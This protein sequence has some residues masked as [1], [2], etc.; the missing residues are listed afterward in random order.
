M[1]RAAI[2][3][4][5][6]HNYAYAVDG[7]TLAV[8]LRAKKN[9]LERVVVHYKNLYDHTSRPEELSMEKILSDGTSD[10]YEAR[11]RV[12]EKR[13]KYYFELFSSGKRVFYTSDGFLESVD[14]KNCFFYP[15]INDDDIFRPPSWAEGE[16]IYQ[17]F[18]D[19][20]HDGDPSNNPPGTIPVGT[21]PGRE[22]YYGGDLEGVILK[23]DYVAG[24]GAKIIYLNP[25][26]LS[27]SYH[28]YDII[29]YY[30]I[31]G[32]FGKTEDL[33]RLVERAHE[34]GMRVVLD[35]VFNHCSSSNPLF[36]DVLERQS[37]SRYR[38]WF[39]IERFPIDAT[40][41]N[42]DTFAGLVPGMPRLNTCNPEV[43]RYI[44][45]IAL[46]WTKLLKLDGWRLDVAD[47]VSHALWIN[48]RRELKALSPDI[49]LIG[50]I[51]NH[52][53]RWLQ[54]REM[55]TA[56]NYK[57]MRALHEFVADKIEARSFWERVSANKMLYRSCL[58]NYL[59][60]LVGSHDTTR[61]RTIL[62]SDELHILAM[63][64]NLT[65]EG[66]PLIYYGDEVCMEGGFDPDN[67]RAMK[68]ED[69]ESRC[70]RKIRELSRFRAGSEILK[71]GSLIPI[72]A[73]RRVLAFYREFE[74]ERLYFLANF[75]VRASVLEGPWRDA[76]VILGE[77]SLEG[78]RL[79]LESG[80]YVL[81]G[82]K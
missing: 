12:K 35:G 41:K 63:A 19:R 66:M 17:I 8:R 32:A 29:D 24:L 30:S 11:I 57:F 20:F 34:R 10:L 40:G 28:K 56:T 70:A 72:E 60:N 43:I 59:V 33:V 54:G 18:V 73:G 25:I 6:E 77:G 39:C 78:G 50:E 3:H 9:D 46:H 15:Y 4:I 49:L 52:S 62:G 69:V 79:A 48:L 55:D 22:S 21:P 37:E 26:F 53:S 45:D 75:D 64:V 47:E 13:F 67:R 65:F 58:Y 1:E 42:Y 23:L 82:D 71:K 31:D 44:T 74:G 14:E 61:C 36:L 16:I 27:N 76:Q 5:S 38:D 7:D 80:R 51:W 2:Y 81:L 68:W